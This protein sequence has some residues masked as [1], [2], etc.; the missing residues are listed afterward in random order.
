MIHEMRM[1]MLPGSDPGCRVSGTCTSH[2]RMPDSGVSSRMPWPSGILSTPNP[3]PCPL[4]LH[5]RAV[6]VCA[7][8]ALIAHTAFILKTLA[9]IL[10][11]QYRQTSS[12]IPRMS[13]VQ[14]WTY[15]HATGGC[16]KCSQAMLCAQVPGKPWRV[17]SRV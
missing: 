12:R 15:V 1:S 17:G 8:M 4:S 2:A 13:Y 10:G 14:D 11:V 7:H 16:G 3:T 6:G 9:L 5:I